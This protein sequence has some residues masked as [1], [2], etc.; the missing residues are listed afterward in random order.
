[1]SDGDGGRHAPAMCGRGVLR[2]RREPAGS[3]GRLWRE[4]SGISSATHQ[5]H[6]P[7]GCPVAAH[8]NSCFRLLPI[9]LFTPTSVRLDCN[10][11]SNETPN[12]REN[13]PSGPHERRRVDRFKLRRDVEPLTLVA[14]VTADS[15][16]SIR[17]PPSSSRGLVYAPLR[18]NVALRFG[19]PPPETSVNIDLGM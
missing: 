5:T 4:P 3:D 15:S 16:R 17:R 1:M 7:S 9:S 10:K 12:L 8:H 14:I 13:T 18:G 6:R 2:R 19:S 11:S